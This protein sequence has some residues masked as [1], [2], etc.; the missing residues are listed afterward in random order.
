VTLSQAPDQP[1]EFAVAALDCG[2]LAGVAVRGEVELATEPA[3]IA[4]VEEAIRG[5]SGPF[6][7]DL[8]AVD[9]VDST[10]IHCL[11]RARALLGRQDRALAILRPRA[12]VRRVLALTGLDELVPVYGS[13]AELARAVRRT[14]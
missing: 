3:F 4:A 14:G 7:I 9:F 10:G 2:G 5:S 13:Y 11:V 8:G 12:N 1:I 6:V